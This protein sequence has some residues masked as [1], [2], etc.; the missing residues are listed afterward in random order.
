MI[1]RV[2]YCSIQT[3]AT[4]PWI[5]RSVHTAERLLIQNSEVWMSLKYERRFKRVRFVD[6]GLSTDDDFGKCANRISSSAPMDGNVSLRLS[7]FWT[8]LYADR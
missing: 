3:F 2:L 5:A 7:C 4:H 6:A 8:S 1:E